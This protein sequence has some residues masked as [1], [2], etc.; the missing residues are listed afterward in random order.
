[1]MRMLRYVFILVVVLVTMTAGAAAAE[2]P[3][4]TVLFVKASDLSVYE[5]QD[6]TLGDV[7]LLQFDIPAE[8]ASVRR[9]Y[10]ELYVDAASRT[11]AGHTNDTPVI[12]VY[13]LKSPFS[14]TVD[15]SQFKPQTLPTAR[16]VVAGTNKRCV[17]DITE[18]VR[19]FATDV[20][21]NH[22]LLVGSLTGDREGVYTIRTDGFEGKGV[23]R[24]T[25]LH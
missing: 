25:L 3:G 23:A 1:M 2:T 6:P 22:G 24:I 21:K 15:P 14:G 8:M 5:S 19:A 13:A 12:E 11:I 16:N 10:L 9:A 4:Q 7:Y 20:T 17:T 18:I